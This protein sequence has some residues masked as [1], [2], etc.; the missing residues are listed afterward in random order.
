[1]GMDNEG[2]KTHIVAGSSKNGQAVLVEENFTEN[3]KLLIGD[4]PSTPFFGKL[5]YLYFSDHRDKYKINLETFC[6]KLIPFCLTEQKKECLRT[7]YNIL[8]IDQDRRLN[9]I[10]L[11]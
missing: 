7:C 4:Y 2:D 3:L 10:N 11:L 5:L 6:N 8:D 9:I 1:M